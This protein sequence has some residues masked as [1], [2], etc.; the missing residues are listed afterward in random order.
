MIE[1][2]PNR[3]LVCWDGLHV[4]LDLDLVERHLRAR[5]ESLEEVSDLTLSGRGDS[6]LLS[7]VVLWKGLRIRVRLV[8]GEIRLKRRFLGMRLHRLRMLGGV[9]VPM[10][11]AE[12]LLRAIASE[13][14]TIVRGQGIVVIDLRRWIPSELDVAVLSVHTTERTLHLWFGP[15]SLGDL[16]ASPRPRLP[17]TTGGSTTA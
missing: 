2:L 15:G 9:P 7:A 13:L 3:P 12:V 1:Q 4:A 6:L 16:P 8:L 5:I 11:A 10:G 17:G 14:V